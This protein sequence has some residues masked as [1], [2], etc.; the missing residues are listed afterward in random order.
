MIPSIGGAFVLKPAPTALAPSP[1]PQVAFT[2]GDTPTLKLIALDPNGNPV[3]L[4]GATLSSEIGGELGAVNTF[5]NGQHTI[6]DQTLYTG[7][8]LLVLSSTDSGNCALG[9]NKDILTTYSL[10]GTIIQLHGMGILNVLSNEPS[11]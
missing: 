1:Q 11:A 5:G 3:N 9:N 7:Q 6:L 8:F 2:Q 10:G 4:A